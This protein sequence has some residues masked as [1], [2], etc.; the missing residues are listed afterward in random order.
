MRTAPLWNDAFEHLSPFSA[1]ATTVHP[2]RPLTGG[3][4]LMAVLRQDRTCNSLAIRE[5]N[6]EQPTESGLYPWNFFKHVPICSGK[7]FRAKHSSGNSAENNTRWHM[8]C[9][10]SVP[11]ASWTTG[12]PGKKAVPHQNTTFYI[13]LIE[14]YKVIIIRAPIP[15]LRAYKLRVNMQ[16]NN[17]ATVGKGYL[18]K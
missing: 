13:A 17:D 16:K 9:I 4:Q 6:G 3:S 1:S 11:D 10:Q 18:V 12:V 7:R 14:C 2:P 15:P 8:F 5:N